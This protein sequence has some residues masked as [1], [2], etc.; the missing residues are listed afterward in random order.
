M[1][2]LY[3][4]RATFQD[5]SALAAADASQG[6]EILRELIPQRGEVDAYPYAAL[7]THKL[8]YLKKWKPSKITET[9][10]ELYRLAQTGIEKHPDDEAMVTAHQ[11]VF[12]EYFMQAVKP[13]MSQSNAVPSKGESGRAVSKDVVGSFR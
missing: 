5:S 1:G 6:E 13:P 11:E 4:K 10:D 3:L 2:V 9:L 8:R 12:R 7:I